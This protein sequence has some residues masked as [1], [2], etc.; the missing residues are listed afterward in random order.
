[1]SRAINLNLTR[2]EVEAAVAKHG[3]VISAIE[4]LYPRG[5]RVVLTSG[6]HA[7]VIRRVCKQQI[8][9]G[10]VLRTPLRTARN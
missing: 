3:V 1:M 5:T 7:A 10:P 4:P 2:R 9:E 6:D 8:I